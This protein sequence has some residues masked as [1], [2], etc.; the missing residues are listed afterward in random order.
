MLNKKKKKAQAHKEYTMYTVLLQEKSLNLLKILFWILI[1]CG[2][3]DPIE[4]R[5]HIT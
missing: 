4:C 3:F 1:S 5:Y 2:S